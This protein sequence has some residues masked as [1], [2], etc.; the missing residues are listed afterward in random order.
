M[1]EVAALP[2]VERRVRF[3]AHMRELLLMSVAD[4]GLEESDV[5]RYVDDA[6]TD[7]DVRN[8]VKEYALD[9]DLTIYGQGWMR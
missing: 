9:Y 5:D 7:Q 3:D 6:V 8:A 4:A 1:S 2:L